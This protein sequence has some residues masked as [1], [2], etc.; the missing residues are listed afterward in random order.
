[1][2][3]ANVRITSKSKRH[4][5]RR[6]FRRNKIELIV[7]FGLI[8]VILIWSSLPAPN[9]PQYVYNKL[10][11]EPTAICND[12]V[13]SFNDLNDGVSSFS[14]DLSDTCLGHGG[15]LRWNPP[16]KE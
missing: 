13:S 14:M 9:N 8:A 5:Y 2:D 3:D 7:S 12:G 10:T 11:K 1:M 4:P 6:W 16:A 15:V